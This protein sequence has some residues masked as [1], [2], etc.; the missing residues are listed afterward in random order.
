MVYV[1]IS[2][3]IIGMTATALIKL[4]HKN[5]ITQITYSNSESARLAVHSGFEKAL[6]FFESDQEDTILAILNKWKKTDNPSTI[7]GGYRWIVGDENKFDSIYSDCKFKV[8]IL[9][10]D[11][12]N[13]SVSLHSE[14]LTQTGGKASAVGTYYLDGLGIDLETS[15]SNA[16]VNALQ[17]DNGNN[18]FNCELY[19]KGN[20]AFSDTIVLNDGPFEFDG[21]FRLDKHPTT[22]A[23]KKIVINGDFTVDSNAYFNQPI[24]CYGSFTFNKSVGFDTTIFIGKT[25]LSVEDSIY[26]TSNIL[27]NGWGAIDLDGAFLRLRSNAYFKWQGGT[28]SYDKVF[29]DYDANSIFLPSV[30]P[31]LDDTLGLG[32]RPPIIHFNHKLALAHTDVY[33]VTNEEVIN[34]TKLNQLYSTKKLWKDKFLVVHFPPTYTTP[35]GN[36]SLIAGDSNDFMGKAIIIVETTSW[37]TMNLNT[38]GSANIALAVLKLPGT[39]DT[40]HMKTRYFRGFVYVNDTLANKEFVLHRGTGLDSDY[41]GAI[42]GSPHVRLRFLG[43][44]DSKHSIF[45]DSTAINELDSL[46]IFSDPDSTITST[47]TDL[48]F[49][50][51]QLESELLSRTF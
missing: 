26:A 23:T 1:M 18:E 3:I 33:T 11:A 46:A 7:T 37:Q 6:A 15:Q 25:N 17:M 8:Q 34:A 10:F 4:S 27:M 51:E 21:K 19:V 30:V 44:S 50:Q 47:D 28:P 13:Y 43:G 38:S 9:G 35:G 24:E 14:G 45:W 16:P 20:C 12:E 29:T 2:L 5:A 22:N 49:T 39:K 40:K 32:D 48:I 36:G 41:H 42:Y 31:N